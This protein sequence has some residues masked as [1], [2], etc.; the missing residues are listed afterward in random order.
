MRSLLPPPMPPAA[1]AL[2][3]T[4]VTALAPALYCSL[5]PVMSVGLKSML[6]TLAGRRLEP[7][8]HEPLAAVTQVAM[9]LTS[10][11]VN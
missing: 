11:T 5:L 4:L 8:V 6:L 9:A 1:G 3:V 2:M 7:T 10:P